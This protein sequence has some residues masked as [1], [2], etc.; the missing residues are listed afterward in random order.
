[1]YTALENRTEPVVSRATRLAEIYEGESRY[2]ESSRFGA[3]REYWR[4]QLDGVGATLTLSTAGITAAA[5]DPGR[6]IAAGELDADTETGLSAAA[7]SFG[8][9]QSALIVAALAGYVRAATGTSDVVLSLP[10]SARTTVALRRSAG[11]VSNVVPIRIRF[12]AHTTLADV[13]KTTELQITGALRH[14]RYR[15]DDIRRDCGYSRDT[16]GFFGPMV[17]LM[18]F[19]N[20]LTFGSLTGSL[21]V[22]STGPVE[23]LSINLYNGAG[24]RIHVDFEANPQL[25]G[26]AELDRHHE[27]FLNYLT[28]FVTAEPETAVAD[29]PVMTG[30]EHETVLR[31]WNATAAPVPSHTLGDLFAARAAATPEAIALE[32]GDRTVT[33]GQLRERVDRLA[34]V[35]IERGAGPDTVI[36]LAM[37]RGV[38]LVVGMY[39]IVRSGAAYLPIDPEHPV[40]RIAQI[41]HRGAPLCVLTTADDW[42]NLPPAKVVDMHRAERTAVVASGPIRDAERRASLRGDHLAYVLFTSGSTGEPK[43][44]GISHSA[45]VNRLAWMQERYRLERTDVV[46]QKT[47]ATFDVSVWEF[48]WPLQ[49]GAKLVLAAPE[50]HRDPAYLARLIEEKGVTTAHFVPSMLSVFV[51]DT[52]VRG[53]AGLRQ[54]FCSGEALPAA[55]V[56]D[57][58][59]A[60][61]GARHSVAPGQGAQLHNLY[62]PT[63]AAVD[64]THW[65]CAPEDEVVPIGAPVHNTQ[66]YVL[67]EMLRPAPPG[68][69]G[70]LYLAGVQLAR[71]YRGRPG[72]TADR[73]VAN[74][75]TPGGRMYRT[76]DLVRWR[77]RPPAPAVLEYLGR[78]DFQVKIRG[79]R[80][81]LGEIEAALLA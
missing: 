9:Q 13:V 78:T 1:I 50:G 22:L 20:E 60:M 38:D 56:R 58:Y 75:F 43:G 32:F 16:R 79:Q 12:D 21:H 44:V 4:A 33:Y 41:V 5:P 46:L 71:G 77:M 45:I 6:L 25:Y 39:A 69:V 35:L 40:E 23:D 81:E 74:P 26:G 61:P 10:M 51:T 57:F 34:R 36:G 18:L 63:E 53:C 73:F 76:G 55:T 8:S 31:D 3:D 70:E 19:H 28:R 11:V 64:V 30:A 59:S 15:H 17:N 67:D 49:I 48:F 66:V 54:V 65:A 7:V 68:T 52:D 37:R 29:V 80:I 47:P 27:R 72:L 14:Q 2:R 24:G 42:A 62:G